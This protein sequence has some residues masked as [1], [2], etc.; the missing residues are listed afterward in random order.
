MRKMLDIHS[1]ITGGPLEL[2]T[3]DE[4][5]SFRGEVIHFEKKYYHCVDSETEFTDDELEKDNL[6]SVYDNYRIKHGIPLAEE[7]TA[8]RTRYRI[9]ARAMSIILGLGENQYRLYEAGTV[10]S[11]SV[12]RLLSLAKDPSNL[13]IMLKAAS[14]SFSQKAYLKYSSSIIA[15]E[16]FSLYE[17]ER[18]S[19]D[20]FEEIVST[21][22]NKAHFIKSSVHSN[23]SKKIPYNTFVLSYAI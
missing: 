10:P 15:S 6:K 8:L 22:H 2:C 9:P 16:I 1:P 19:F 7:L 11:V 14:S 4:S 20:E 23:K 21:I 18:I 5:I 12:G 13:I 3:S 17:N